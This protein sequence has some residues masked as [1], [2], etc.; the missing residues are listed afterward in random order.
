MQSTLAQAFDAIHARHP[1]ML[2][3]CY[4][5]YEAV[6]SR[7][8]WNVL[9]SFAQLSD[10]AAFST[11]PSSPV[12]KA[13]NGLTAGQLPSDY[14]SDIGA[15][16]GTS[17][18]VAFVEVG[19]PA[20]PTPLFPLGSDAEQAMFIERILDILPSNTTLALWTY[21]FDPDLSGVYPLEI[22]DHF[23]AM[24]QMRLI[25]STARQPTWGR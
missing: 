5:Q 25:D 20:R 23:G 22:A 8:L 19:H 3:F 21:L 7:D 11:Y 12:A 4:F 2:V 24:G 16:W 9:E 15:R 17:H 18:Q 10:V 6:K 1:N 13:P 14:F